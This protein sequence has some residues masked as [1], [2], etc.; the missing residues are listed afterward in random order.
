MDTSDDPLEVL[1]VQLQEFRKLLVDVNEGGKLMVDT[2]P[3]THP[4]GHKHI[5]TCILECVCLCVQSKEEHL[6]RK[7][8]SVN[9]SVKVLDVE[10]LPQ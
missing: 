10:S 6:L 2:E 8:Q 5:H 1:N 7:N 3:H 9:Q 4:Q